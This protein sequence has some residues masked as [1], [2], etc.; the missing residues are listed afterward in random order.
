MAQDVGEEAVAA[1]GL[2]GAGE[3]EEGEA[4]AGGPGLAA[5][6]NEPKARGSGCRLTVQGWRACWAGAEAVASSPEWA[7]PGRKREE[8]EKEEARGPTGERACGPK[9]RRERREWKEISF[10]FSFYK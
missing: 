8:G 4:L 6:E 9:W 10:F 1:C 2:T 3:R 7:G 5:V